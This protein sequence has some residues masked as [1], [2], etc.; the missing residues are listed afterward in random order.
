[1]PRRSASDRRISTRAAPP[2]EIELELAAV[3]VPSLRNAG[4][5]LPI[6]SG[7]A[8]PGCSSLVTWDSP[9]RVRTVWGAISASKVPSSTAVRA[10]VS[11][12]TA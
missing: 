2:S 9:F 7:T 6:L 5:R 1:M 12:A 10:R 11:E 8:L 3:T 4:L